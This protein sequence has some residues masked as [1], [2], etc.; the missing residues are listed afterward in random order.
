MITRVHKRFTLILLIF[1]CF[2]LTIEIKAENL[3]DSTKTKLENDFGLSLDKKDESI[4][5]SEEEGLFLHKFL[6]TLPNSLTKNTC[7]ISLAKVSTTFSE[8]LDDDCSTDFD[9]IAIF[10]QKE[11]G[12]TLGSI[13]DKREKEIAIFLIQNNLVTPDNE[14]DSK[15][16]LSYLARSVVQRYLQKFDENKDISEKDSWLKLSSWEWSSLLKIPI[17]FAG[18]GAENTHLS[19]FAHPKGLNS[20]RDDF[21]TFGSSFFSTPITYYAK[22]IKCINPDKFNFFRNLF[23][24][25]TPHLDNPEFK[26]RGIVCPRIDQDISSFMSFM[27]LN[28]K[29]KIEIGPINED[30]VKGFELIYATPGDREISEIAGHLMLRIKLDNNP[31]LDPKSENPYDIII[32][33]LADNNAYFEKSGKSKNDTTKSNFD[34]CSKDFKPPSAEFKEL[35]NNTMQALKGLAGGFRTIFQVDTFQYAVN[36][37]TIESNRTLERFEFVL[38]KNQKRDLLKYL[39]KVVK[40]YKTDYYFFNKNCG[41]ILI[42]LLGE[43]LGDDDIAIYNTLTSPPNSLIS[44]LIKKGIVKPV[45]PHIYSYTAKAQIASDIIKSKLSLL[46]EKY[47]DEN[48]PDSDELNDKDDNVR[49]AAYTRLYKISLKDPETRDGILNI[50][51]IA[52]KSELAYTWN[53]GICIR[54]STK[55]KG[56]VRSFI[57]E[58]EKQDDVNVDVENLISNYDLNREI[59]DNQTSTGH[60]GL[61]VFETGIIFK[62]DR[63]NNNDLYTYISGTVYKQKMGDPSRRAMLRG[64]SVELGTFEF[65]YND[66]GD[67]GWHFTGLKINKIKA[68][69]HY[70]PSVFSI[71]RKFGLGFTLLEF[72]NL[73]KDN[74]TYS[75]IPGEIEGFFSLCSSRLFLDYLIV[76]GGVGLETWADRNKNPLSEIFNSNT[77]IGFPIGIEVQLTF[78]ENRFLQINGSYEYKTY[79]EFPGSYEPGQPESVSTITAGIDIRFG[80][81]W[82]TDI[83]LN[84]KFK[85][86]VFDAKNLDK[87][88]EEIVRIGL[89]FYMW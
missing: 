8:F 4:P 21:T 44:L 52:Q 43:A 58:M 10:S 72:E 53:K 24:E 12:E 78:G 71:H 56:V 7:Q 87:D 74:E 6:T 16:Y 17:P 23:P 83:V 25:Y 3:L 85:Y 54:Y 22:S 82:N 15:K 41:S 33:V 63:N 79:I 27:D 84:T 50:F 38:T 1:L 20:P 31:G 76:K 55:T 32:A 11:I 30:T 60:T 73:S 62:K 45:Y 2:F 26:K 67:N 64:T 34:P 77:T 39:H 80:E 46:A 61:S 29:D 42:K 14:A 13:K 65:D 81:L 28:T 9:E 68:R 88:D 51:K 57:R 86:K 47:K 70:I 69:R 49:S 48:F 75:I 18:M 40:N 66:E 5:W 35:Y 36:H 59:K 89:S 37:Y 19:G